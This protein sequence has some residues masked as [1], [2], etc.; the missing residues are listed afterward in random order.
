MD[1]AAVATPIA[2]SMGEAAPLRRMYPI[3]VS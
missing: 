1:I 3:A 2:S